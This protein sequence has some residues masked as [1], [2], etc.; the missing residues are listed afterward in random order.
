MSNLNMSQSDKEY[1]EFRHWFISYYSHNKDSILNKY[2]DKNDI[3][4][5]LNNY[6]IDIGYNNKSDHIIKR[7]EGLYLFD[8]VM[9]NETK[10][11]LKNQYI[12]Y[13]NDPKNYSVLSGINYL[14]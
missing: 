5:Q 3:D 6:I 12:D 2:F 4:Q 1:I 8:H 10:I 11:K 14:I 9:S 7:K 13:I